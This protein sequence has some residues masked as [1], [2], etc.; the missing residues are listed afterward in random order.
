MLERKQVLVIEMADW[1]VEMEAE[2]VHVCQ[3]EEEIR[4]WPL[5]FMDGRR[6]GWRNPQRLKCA[7]AASLNAEHRGDG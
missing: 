6:C 1:M 5:A 2:H 3:S 4:R 7:W